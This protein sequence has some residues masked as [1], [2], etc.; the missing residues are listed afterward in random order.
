MDNWNAGGY[1]FETDSHM[2]DEDDE[3]AAFEA[4]C[5]KKLEEEHERRAKEEKEAEIAKAAE[6]ARSVAMPELSQEPEPES[7]P[8]G[9][10]ETDAEPPAEDAQEPEPIPEPEP[11]PDPEPEQKQEPVP[12]QRKMSHSD[13][14]AAIMQAESQESIRHSS[15]AQEESY[16]NDDEEDYDSD[17]E[18]EN[19]PDWLR[20][21]FTLL[22]L[23]LGG[24]GIYVMVG[25]DYHSTIFDPLCFMEIAVCLL[26][27]VGLN[28]ASI[29]FRVA[30][31]MI[32]RIAA[33]ALFAYYVIY[34]SDALFLKRLL[35][36]GIDKDH[37]LAYAKTHINA[38]VV[39]GLTAMGNSGMLGCALFVLPIAFMLLM[40]FRPFRNIVLYLL[41]VAFLFFAVGTLRILTMSGTFDFSQGCMA[42]TGTVAAYILFIFPPLQRLMT[43]SGLILWEYD[44][45]EE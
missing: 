14:L 39:E 3:M 26:T 31:E 33:Y 38:D 27:A 30:K 9:E 18:K 20:L 25:M 28:A 32:M 41:T 6:V 11:E 10:S 40:L 35:A 8:D 7:E 42:V 13:E 12:E 43:D 4:E 1:S 2:T 23:I 36:Y 5:A 24:I 45:E 19:L 17:N 16:E 29:P 22:L 21:L 37:A 44:D 15:A 34:A